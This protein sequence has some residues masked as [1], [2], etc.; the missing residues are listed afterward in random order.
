M[1]LSSDR[2]KQLA[3]QEQA[4]RERLLD[5]SNE[6][7]RIRKERGLSGG[8]RT[9]RDEGPDGDDYPCGECGRPW[10]DNE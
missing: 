10:D 8:Y 7:R 2:D 9:S 5:A 6:W 3:K 4:A 1:K